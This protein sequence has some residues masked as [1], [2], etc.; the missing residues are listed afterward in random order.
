MYFEYLLDATLGPREI[1]YVIECSICGFDEI[2]YKDPETNQFIG[3]ACANCNSLQKFDITVN[4]TAYE[5][6]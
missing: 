6:K 2:Y 4:E 3:R 5:V 1:F